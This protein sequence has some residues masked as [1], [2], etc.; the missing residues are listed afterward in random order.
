MVRIVV[1]NAEADLAVL[2]P[3]GEP[4]HHLVVERQHLPG[5]TRHELA[6]LGRL[7]AG[8]LGEEE[9]SRS[10]WSFFIC[11]LMAGWVRPSCSAA[12]VWLRR[13]MTARKVRRR[14]VGMFL[15][16]SAPLQKETG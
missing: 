8:I 7:G 14:S 16:G 4:Q 1:G 12:R 13:S 2:V 15:T 5:I 6:R 10:S 3:P 9:T 11:R